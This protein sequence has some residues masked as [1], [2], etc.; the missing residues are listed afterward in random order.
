MTLQLPP[1]MSVMNT[2]PEQDQD[3]QQYLTQKSVGETQFHLFLCLYIIIRP[4]SLKFELITLPPLDAGQI[5]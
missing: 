5:G 4:S 2:T 1:S 3:I